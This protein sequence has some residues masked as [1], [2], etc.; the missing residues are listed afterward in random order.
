MRSFTEKWTV[1]GSGWRSFRVSWFDEGECWGG[2]RHFCHATNKIFYSSV[3]CNCF[4]SSKSCGRPEA[5]LTVIK[6]CLPIND[7]DKWVSGVFVDAPDYKSLQDFCSLLS[8]STEVPRTPDKS[9]KSTLTRLC[10][11]SAKDNPGIPI[12]T[13]TRTGGTPIWYKVALLSKIIF[14]QIS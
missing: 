1:F 5:S 7:T 2:K 6:S 10:Q 12:N 3:C 9:S 13:S 11:A 8:P 4:A 14:C